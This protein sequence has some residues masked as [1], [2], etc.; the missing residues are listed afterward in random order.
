MKR[1]VS[2]REAW[3]QKGKKGKKGKNSF[4]L[5]LFFLPFLLPRFAIF[6][7]RLAKAIQDNLPKEQR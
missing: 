4:L 1:P 3:R 6:N 7:M 5:F 2:W